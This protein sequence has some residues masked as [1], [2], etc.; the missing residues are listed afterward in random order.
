MPTSDCS[1]ARRATGTAPRRRSCGRPAALVDRAPARAV[2]DDDPRDRHGRA[3]RGRRPGTRIGRSR[4]G[5][6]PGHNMTHMRGVAPWANVQ[7]RLALARTSLLLSDRA[8]RPHP[9]RGGRVADPRPAGRASDP[10]PSSPSSRRCSTASSARAQWTA[11]SLTTAE[12]RV[13]HYLPTNLTL[14]D[15]AE[16]LYVSRNT[17]KSHAIAIY[18]KLG[19]KHPG[20]GGGDRR[21]DRAAARP[22]SRRAARSDDLLQEARSS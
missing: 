17:T 5:G 22:R 3:P 20:R 15:I 6:S 12:L 19:T 1:G 11:Y 16:R 9:H 10:R 13:L 4:S 2:P 18:R 14:S 7:S 21:G 8:A